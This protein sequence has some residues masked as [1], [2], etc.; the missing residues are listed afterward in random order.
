M[1]SRLQSMLALAVVA[2]AMMFSSCSST[3]DFAGYYPENRIIG[4]GIG[5]GEQKTEVTAV[6]SKQETAVSQ[7]QVAEEQ[8]VA[9]T[10]TAPAKQPTKFQQKMLTAVT[11]MAANQQMQALANNSYADGKRFALR[12]KLAQKMFN[13]FAAQQSAMPSGNTADIMAIVSIATGAAAVVTYY[14]AFLFGLAAIVTGAL[15]L[16]WGTSRRGMAIGGIVLGAFALV[17]WALWIGWWATVW[18]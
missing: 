10:E 7:T 12:E 9:T 15:A 17:F 13:K 18:F 6:E 14:G 4:K 8:T 11:K 1:K 3:Q 5:K 2:G 16:A